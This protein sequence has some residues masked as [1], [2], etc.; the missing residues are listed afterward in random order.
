MNSEDLRITADDVLNLNRDVLVATARAARLVGTGL[1]VI[2]AVGA[3]L[4]LWLVLR[5]QQLIGEADGRFVFG[6]GDDESPSTKERLD[7]MASVFGYLVSVALTGGAGMAL[8]MAGQY[9]TTTSG[10][11]LTAAAVGDPLPSPAD[12]LWIDDDAAGTDERGDENLP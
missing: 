4:W 8:R 9:L 7:L 10:G 12:D 5:Q 6:T 3:L 2:A 11:S 1:L